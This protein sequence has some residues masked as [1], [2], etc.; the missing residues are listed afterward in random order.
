MKKLKLMGGSSKKG[1]L[2]KGGIFGVGKGGVYGKK[3]SSQWKG[4]AFGKW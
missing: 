1:N 3:K 2:F 4:G